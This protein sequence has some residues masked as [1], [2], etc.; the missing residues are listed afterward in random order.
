MKAYSKAT[1]DRSGSQINE[2]IF[3]HAYCVKKDLEYVGS[4][5]QAH[6]TNH[7]KL[8]EL[9][10]L[11]L[12]FE[13]LPPTYA[14]YTEVKPENYSRDVY[15]DPNLLL[16]QDFIEMLR[17][18]FLLTTKAPIRSQPRAAVHIRRGDVKINNQMRYM[19]NSYY[20]EVI[21][22]IQQ[23]SPNIDV[24][25]FSE[26]NSS[27]NFKVFRDLGCKLF[28]DADL[29][30]TWKEMIFA[31]VLVMS[32][33]S[34]AYVPAI[35]N[36]NFIIYYPAWYSKL[37]HWHHANDPE[38]WNKLKLFLDRRYALRTDPENEK[39]KG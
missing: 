14:H 23:I 2:D 9:L 39:M 5:G 30:F 15:P 13:K 10:N 33:G 21:K 27:E 26:S 7:Y 11:P 6:F 19:P 17:Q 20:V 8:S 22:N 31:D 37:A 18:K 1:S 29:K 35:Y 24:A 32:K 36:N 28:L 12:P 34:F 3:V 25:I 16:D 4:Y 38:L